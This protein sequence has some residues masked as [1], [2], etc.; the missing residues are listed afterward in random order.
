LDEAEANGE[1][2]RVRPRSELAEVA[3]VVWTG[4]AATE[5]AHTCGGSGDGGED[6]ELEVAGV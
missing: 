2:L 3:V 1:G 6:V 5:E 4:A